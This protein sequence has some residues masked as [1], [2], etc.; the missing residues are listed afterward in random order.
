ML[1]EFYSWWITR[2]TEILPASWTNADAQPRDGVVIDIVGDRDIGTSLRRRGLE[3]PIGLGAAARI[4]GRKAVM[5]RPPPRIVLVKN[6]VMPTA[7]RR[8]LDLML[9]HELSRITPFSADTLFWRWEGRVRTGDRSKTETV[10]TMV[11]K[12]PLAA[13]FAEL[14]SVGIR[15]DFIEVGP[16]ERPKLLPVA[17]ATERNARSA[18]ARRL[19]VV[20]SGLAVAALGLP[21]LLQTYALRTTEA[22][23]TG[24]QPAI[25]EVETLRRAVAARNGA[26]DIM[27]QEAA[28]TGDVLQ[29]LATVTRILPDDSYL[30]DFALRE[31]Q[32]TISGR[33]GSAPRLIT[34][35]S[36][37]PAMRDPAFAAPVTRAEGTASEV[38]SIKAEVVR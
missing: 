28:R 3:S 20:C 14:D 25:K 22:S 5:L 2:I 9:H 19:A 6:H 24:L 37:D 8:D 11:P 13:A 36:A 33:T 12:E 30:T 18:L 27:T 15:V 38:F 4:A 26:Q 34:G 16:A 21:L 10:V 7:P 1:A 32:L 35:L 17:E 31:R 29:V 23:I